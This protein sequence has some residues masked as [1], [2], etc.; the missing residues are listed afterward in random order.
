MNS[1]TAF[2]YWAEV[3]HVGPK[4]PVKLQNVSEICVGRVCS[5]CHKQE[6][7][8]SFTLGNK[9]FGFKLRYTD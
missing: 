3:N 7:N 6:S 1:D 4:S 9:D 5:V 2:D 8:C